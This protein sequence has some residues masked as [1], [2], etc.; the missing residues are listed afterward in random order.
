[1]LEDDVIATKYWVSLVEKQIA[2]IAERKDWAYLKLY[3]QNTFEGWGKETFWELM[4][5]CGVCG[6][7]SSIIATKIIQSWTPKVRALSF[8]LGFATCLNTLIML[9][10]QHVILDRG[11]FDSG[12]CCTPAHLYPAELVLS[13]SSY[14]RTNYDKNLLDLL[15]DDW[16]RK[17]VKLCQLM[18]RPSLFQHIGMQS[19]NP[20]K[21]PDPY[22]QRDT[23]FIEVT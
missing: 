14:M 9:G 22:Y 15:V 17:D 12:G 16:A 23:N 2:P 10:R 20:G 5:Y 4:L 21:D 18:L 11:I 3:R 8:A 6:A 1:M 13:L 19:S 7:L